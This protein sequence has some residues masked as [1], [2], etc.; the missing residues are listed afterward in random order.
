MYTLPPG[1]VWSGTPVPVPPIE[2]VVR[3][4]SWD[5]DSHPGLVNQLLGFARLFDAGADA[6]ATIL[7]VTVGSTC[8]AC[9][10]YLLATPRA[11]RGNGRCGAQPVHD[12]RTE[13]RDRFAGGALLVVVVDEARDE[14]CAPSALLA[15]EDQAAVIEH[16]VRAGTNDRIRASRVSFERRHDPG[17]RDILGIARQQARAPR[18][19]AVLGRVPAEPGVTRDL[20]ADCRKRN[21]DRAVVVGAREAVLRIAARA[22]HRRLVLPLQRPVA[23][24]AGARDDVD[25]RAGRPLL[26][27]AGARD[28]KADDRCEQYAA[29]ESTDGACTPGV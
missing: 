11:S 1:N 13:V 23:V 19:A 17:W 3:T 27:R 29:S 26:L 6:T 8:H 28:G 7:D 4:R 20:L 2:H 15:L 25:V 5:V 21:V 22:G 12:R 18:Q 10:L 24:R 14:D 9:G 16:P